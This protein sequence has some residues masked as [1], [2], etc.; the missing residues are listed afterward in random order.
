MRALT[1][2]GLALLLAI[3]AAFLSAC[4][5]DDQQIKVYRVSKAPL[6]STPPP[7]DMSMAPNSQVPTNAPS[8]GTDGMAPPSSSDKPQIKWEVP[9]G[10]TSVPASAMRHASFAAEK[11]GQKADISVV[12]FPGEGG[13]DLDNVNRWRGQIGLAP[14]QSIESVV[15]PVSA[16]GV[17]FS[18]VDMA[19]TSS[20][21]LAAWTRRDG[22]S[23]FFKLTGSPNLVE[24]EK[25][26]FTAFLQSVS[27]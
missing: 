11:D 4:E 21:M 23:W 7:M 27:F 24:Q 20:R 13:S 19:G 14:L 8:P 22:R 5:R 3:G 2:R 1:I 16:G 25:A 9:A 17:Q 12:T 6:E 15:V 10:W 18:M 26:K